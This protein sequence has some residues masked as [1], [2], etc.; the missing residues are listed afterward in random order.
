VGRVAA[1]VALTLEDFYGQTGTSGG[2]L[3][4]GYWQLSGPRA[5]LHDFTDVPGVEISGSI[6]AK[7]T[8]FRIHGRLEGTL[9]EKGLTVTG[10]LGGEAVHLHLVVT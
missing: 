7:G 3:R 6:T 5:T 9:E 10:H 2:G 4:G 8:H 1:A